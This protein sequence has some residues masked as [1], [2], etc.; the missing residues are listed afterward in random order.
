[1]IFGFYITAVIIAV[2][3]RYEA[4]NDED[5]DRKKLDLYPLYLTIVCVITRIFII[6]I[7]YGTSAVGIYLGLSTSN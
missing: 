3:D 1:M 4:Y 5:P 7:R 2:I 6:A